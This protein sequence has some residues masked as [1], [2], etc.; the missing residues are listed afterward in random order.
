[1]AK[2]YHVITYQENSTGTESQAVCSC[3]D[4]SG[5]YPGDIIKADSALE[6]WSKDHTE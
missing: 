4:K 2:V 1:M 3:G 6:H 5:W